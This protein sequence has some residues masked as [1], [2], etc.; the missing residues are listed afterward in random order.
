MTS[1]PRSFASDNNAGACPEVLAAV[2]AANPGHV[3]AYGSDDVTDHL[4]AIVRAEFGPQAET[5]PVFNGTG[6][7]VVALGAT[8]RAWD[9]VICTELAHINADEGGA[10]EAIAGLKLVP[11]PA[12]DGKLTPEL[13]ESQ[14]WGFDDVHRARPAVVSLTE[15]TEMGTVYTPAEIRALADQAHSHGMRLHVDGARLANA[16][17]SLGVSLAEITSRAGADLVT[18]GGTKNGAIA[19]EAVITFDPELA[20]AV[21]R[22]RKTFG[23][24]SSKMRFISAQLVALLSDRVWHR[25]A[26]HANAMATRLEAAVRG[27]PGLTICR[28]VE[29]NGVFAILP[30]DA[31]ARL[32]ARHRF[33][34][35]NQATGEVRWMCSWDTTPAEVDAFAAD[36]GRAITG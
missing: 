17:A 20:E 27:I 26:A 18:F 21:R 33:Y 32:Q 31:T 4:Q 11:V 24:L 7:N 3:P 5:F 14:A 28:P 9:A 16:A 25:N 30:P 1:R 10:P 23:Q 19:A 29:A 34:T 13:V 12:P 22:L 15:S 8:C 6:G 36:V 2:A 35:W